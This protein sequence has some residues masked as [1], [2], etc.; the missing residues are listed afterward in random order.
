MCIQGTTPLSRLICEIEDQTERL[1]KLNELLSRT[2][3][4][5]IP[6]AEWVLIHEQQ[7]VLKQLIDILNTRLHLHI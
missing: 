1:N 7:Y 4:N 6:E 5:F 2:R 3:P